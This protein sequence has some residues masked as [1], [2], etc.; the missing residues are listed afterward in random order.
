MSPLS[1]NL[2]EMRENN[3]GRLFQQAT[4]AYSERALT[5]LH[6][7]GFSDI[8]LFHTVLISNLDTSGSQITTIADKAGITKQAMGQLVNEL[9]SKGYV[10]KTKNQHDKRAYLI[11]FT[12]HGK[13]ALRAAYEVKIIIDNEYQARLGVDNLKTL[14]TLLQTLIDNP[15]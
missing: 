12:E 7:R 14:R 10:K 11:Q 6:E 5:L 15:A 2:I 3:I 9:E 4:R 1:K 8:T 13:D